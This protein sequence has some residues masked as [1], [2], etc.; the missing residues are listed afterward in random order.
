[1]A[2]K[3][4]IEETLGLEEEYLPS[5]EVIAD[6]FA[7]A[8]QFE[9]HD[10]LSKLNLTQKDLSRKMGIKPPSLSAMLRKGAN[11]TIR[12]MARIARALGFRLSAPKL[13]PLYEEQGEE[14]Y[15]VVVVEVEVK[16]SKTPASVGGAAYSNA[17]GSEIKTG[18][19]DNEEC[20]FMPVR[21]SHQLSKMTQD[22][23][24]RVAA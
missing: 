18:A 21:A 22:L 20:E 3:F 19:S 24:G 5:Y 9:V 10:K 23:R 6:N 12:S 17:E 14:V 1:M 11:L 15:D 2:V 8:F 16:L 4:S 7:L 13:I